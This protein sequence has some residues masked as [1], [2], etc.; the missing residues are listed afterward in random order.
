LVHPGPVSVAPAA[1]H[2]RQ[3]KLRGHREPLPSNVADASNIP[4]PRKAQ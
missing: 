4:R 3:A 1:S 2:R